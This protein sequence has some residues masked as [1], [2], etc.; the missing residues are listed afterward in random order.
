MLRALLLVAA[1][2]LA[3]CTNGRD[4]DRP[5]AYLGSFKMGHGIVL[6]REPVKGPASREASKDDMIASLDKAIED[7]FRR[8][9]GE[10]FYHLAINIEGYVL[11]QPGIPIVLSPKSVMIVS[12]TVIEDATGKKLNEKPE[13]ITGL[14][15]LSGDTI[16]GS[17]LTL[18]AEEQ[19]ENLSINTAKEI[20]KWLVRMN[21]KEKWFGGGKL[22][23]NR[24]KAKEA[25]EEATAK[26]DETAATTDTE[27]LSEAKAEAEEAVE[28]ALEDAKET[29]V[30]A[31][32]CVPGDNEVANCPTDA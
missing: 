31:P 16:V 6:A 23:G 19:L 25:E 11:A 32:D 15:S 4:L 20:E 5:P 22:F 17:G 9:E 12:V 28:G 14:E 18:S 29:A 24:A 26:E 3:A 21:R 8:Y 1:T 10:S 27:E 2:M 30:D 7:R 13:Q